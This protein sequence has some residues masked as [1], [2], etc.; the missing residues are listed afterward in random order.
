MQ[1]NDERRNEGGE[2]DDKEKRP[3]SGIERLW[4]EILTGTLQKESIATLYALKMVLDA[5]PDARIYRETSGNGY[6]YYTLKYRQPDHATGHMTMVS[7]YLGQP[8]DDILKRMRASLDERR[9]NP[10]V[11]VDLLEFETDKLRK[12][13]HLFRKALA[14]A[15]EIA[16]NTPFRFHGHSLRRQA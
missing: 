1:S 6:E 7:L 8:E 15:R 2:A 13:K 14:A 4:G 5:P 16:R 12:L 10:P 11:E 9:K 3:L